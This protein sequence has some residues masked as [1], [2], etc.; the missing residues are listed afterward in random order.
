MS[1]NLWYNYRGQVKGAYYKCNDRECN[2]HHGSPIV[3][4]EL[5][6]TMV[7]EEIK[8]FVHDPGPVLAQLEE[9]AGVLVGIGLKDEIRQ[10]E[11]ALTRILD[12]RQTILYRLRKRLVSDEEGDNQLIATGQEKGMLEARLESLKA[13]SQNEEWQRTRLEEAA[14]LLERLKE[15][16]ESADSKTKREVVEILV[17]GIT[18]KAGETTP[19][20]SVTYLF[21]TPRITSSMLTPRTT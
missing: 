13:Q 12:E 2:Q 17:Q 15:R 11:K 18:V 9:Q 1:H 19:D 8:G 21:E 3:R 7:W 16:V 4:A 5:L 6:E 10:A 20:V 14:T